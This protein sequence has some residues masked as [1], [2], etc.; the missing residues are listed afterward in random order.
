MRIVSLH[1]KN[2]NSLRTEKSIHF[3]E[4]PLGNTGLFA[5]VGDT[6][7][8]K[9]TILD[10]ITLALY[11]HVP[12]FGDNKAAS[13]ILSHGATDAYAHVVFEA[14]GK[15]YLAEWSIRR[16]YGKLDGNLRAPVRKL[17]EY[18]PGKE[19]FTAIAEK[20]GEVDKA[21]AEITGLDYFQFL[22]SVLLAQG[23]FAAFLKANVQERSD[24]LERIT[25]LGIY[26]EI[27]RAAHYRHRKEE[28]T[29]RELE[30]KKESLQLLTPGE[31]EKL[32]AELT[33]LETATAELKKQNKSLRDQ[34]NQIE[35]AESLQSQIAG[36]EK[37]EKDLGARREELREITS[38]LERF[39]KALPFRSHIDS[40]D[41]S[42]AQKTQF[43]EQLAGIQSRDLPGMVEQREALGLSLKE[44]RQRLK[45]KRDALPA[46]FEKLDAVVKLDFQI[47]ELSAQLEREKGLSSKQE[48]DIRQTQSLLDE[49]QREMAE[50]EPRIRE[51]ESWLEENAFLQ[52]LPADLGLLV[53]TVADWQE[54]GQRA[55]NLAKQLE[56]KNETLAREEAKL[57]SFA[58]E[59]EKTRAETTRKE[60]ALSLLKPGLFAHSRAEL[61]S[62]QNRE[63]QG[64]KEKMDMLQRL[65]ALQNDYHRL[66]VEQNLYTDQLADLKSRELDL[67][68]QFLAV[69][70]QLDESLRDL[71][72]KQ[73]IYEQQ[74]RIASYQKDRHNLK[75]GEPCPLCFSTHHPFH[76]HPVEEIYVDQAGE[77]V[78]KSKAKAV[79]LQ[80]QQSEL[81]SRLNELSVQ[82]EV[83]TGN[84]KKRITGLLKRQE[85][86]MEEQEGRMN[87]L[88][89][90]FEERE[91]L[92]APDFRRQRQSWYRE[93][94]ES[95][96][97]TWGL[98]MEG[99]GELEALK[100]RETELQQEFQVHEFL[101]RELRNE[102]LSRQDGLSESLSRREK[103][104]SELR[105]LL[106]KYR[107]ALVE[108]DL[109]K[110]L[111]G[112]QKAGEAW[113]SKNQEIS[114]LREGQKEA[115]DKERNLLE[116]FS[117]QKKFLQDTR[118]SL[119]KTVQ[120]L[121]DRTAKRFE[122]LEDRNPSV[123]RD[124]LQKEVDDLSARI[125]EEKEQLTAVETRIEALQAQAGRLA[126]DI[127]ALEKAIRSEG[128]SLAGKLG[129]A[130][131]RSSQEVQESLIPDEE[132]G[133]MEEDVLEFNKRETEVAQT[134]KTFR[135]QAKAVLAR[136]PGA[137]DREAL[138][139]QADSLEK[140]LEE[141]QIRLGRLKG[142]LDRG[143]K[144]EK[145]ARKLQNRIG[146][147]NKELAR[148]KVLT[149]LIGS[150][151]GK[152]FRTFAQGLTLE[153]LV[154]LANQHLLHLD[155]RYQIQ[156]TRGEGLELEIIDTY[157]ANNIRSMQTLSGGES[158]LVSLA[159][160]LGLS[161][162]AGQRSDIRSLFVDEGFGSLDEA[163][164]D[165]AI[166]TLENLQAKGKTI[167]IISHVKELKER[168]SAQIQIIKRS[169]GFSEVEVVG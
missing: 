158:F 166:S 89:G 29:L 152:R 18:D 95:H 56:E 101:V 134:L 159:L 14:N 28:N 68:G 161:D 136:L 37:E 27:S 99:M 51:L 154:F 11:G 83:L 36:L 126:E 128:L 97:K 16:A 64:W 85:K 122:L 160:A 167:G 9:T 62:L 50:R 25:G 104:I 94:L 7:S 35:L 115:R 153:R 105:G 23:E 111:A 46:H 65:E 71:D 164:L 91:G 70:D 147:Q 90:G 155:G 72:Y 110:Q 86:K 52:T 163:S 57:A 106:L 67:F 12:R 113:Q 124:R 117:G 4:A 162:L 165:I 93:Q 55:A 123:E 61:V 145:E 32:Q 47:Q 96:Q 41:K 129:K 137:W 34:L 8:G 143:E 81:V 168:I 157:Q 150:A 149:D 80:G 156:K 17:S 63:L 87:E 102:I 108:G 10:A 116:R 6:G 22:R 15:K 13:E 73:S 78:K 88:L 42:E 130:G 58:P 169:N 148:W 31:K 107:V 1:I 44:N 2:L 60:E 20:A 144:E 127:D 5:I 118:D 139:L 151:D 140:Q 131:F 146:R 82:M 53:R 109:E 75:E 121:G 76:R 132:A 119:R 24:L 92:H 39:K 38:R 48:E 135:Q 79:R 133:K 49:L 54:V 84:E 19:D 77:E 98:I 74:L 69:T 26:T 138:Q 141:S 21:V 100:Q 30:L 40:L 103:S 114:R 125:G 3:L 66:L 43:A 33:G 142:S 45:E 120:T 59:L 112:L